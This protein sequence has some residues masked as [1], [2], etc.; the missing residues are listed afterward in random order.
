MAKQRP[1]VLDTVHLQW[2]LVLLLPRCTS[3]S[4]NKK[5]SKKI[6]GFPTRGALTSG[7]SQ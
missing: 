6:L 1:C 7:L 2:E 4:T 5:V 3:R